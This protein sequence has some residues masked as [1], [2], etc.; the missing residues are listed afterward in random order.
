MF[1]AQSN[2]IIEIRKNKNFYLFFNALVFTSILTIPSIKILSTYYENYSFYYDP[3]TGISKGILFYQRMFEESHLNPVFSRLNF[4]IL[5]FQADP[6]TALFY[7]P[8]ILLFPKLLAT[9]FAIVPAIFIICLIFFLIFGNALYQRGQSW[10]IIIFWS[11]ILASA[12]VYWDIF[13]GII[14]GWYD[15]PTG[16]L[17]SSSLICLINWM[18]F[19]SKRSLYFAVLFVSLTC[20]ARS[21]FAVYGVITFFPAFLYVSVSKIR[22][23]EISLH[24]FLIHLFACL[25]LAFFI[26]GVYHII[27]YENNFFYYTKMS[28]TGKVANSFDSFVSFIKLSKVIG[29]PYVLSFFVFFFISAKLSGFNRRNLIVSISI[30]FMLLVFWIGYVMLIILPLSSLLFLCLRKF[31]FA[32]KFNRLFIYAGFILFSFW[33]LYSLSNNLTLA[34]SPS[35]EARNTKHI[36]SSIASELVSTDLNLPWSAYFEEDYTRIVNCELFFK[37]GKIQTAP[38]CLEQV[39]QDP[40]INA[41]YGKL[42]TNEIISDKL[43][44]LSLLKLI[45]IHSNDSEIDQHIEKRFHRCRKITHAILGHILTNN[46][47][48]LKKTFKSK[49]YGNLSLFINKDKIPES[50]ILKKPI[51]THSQKDTNN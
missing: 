42:S 41:E 22:S 8:T 7:I 5:H 20:I 11:L 10:P 3:V 9:P 50:A 1:F 28:V 36:N 24:N 17:L 39:L 40:Y 48:K 51:K 25:I 6:K 44:K 21:I 37:Y 32:K 14:T 49:K 38:Y 29:I 12:P 2:F 47:W 4:A 31:D 45:I 34:Q 27:H 35:F 43:A 15:L 19:N 13:R 26:A 23:N 33:T 30:L 16:F 46:N 18:E